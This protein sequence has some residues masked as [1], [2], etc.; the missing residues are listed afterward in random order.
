MSSKTVSPVHP[1]THH[2]SGMSY[3]IMGYAIMTVF[4]TLLK[5]VSQSGLYP[6][7]QMMATVGLFCAATIALVALFTGGLRGR[8]GT[9]KLAFHLWRGLLSLGAFFVGF[10]ALRHIPLVDFYGII[11]AIP[12]FV[13]LLSV[14]WL[15]EH[16]GW[17]RWTAIGCGFIGVLLMLRM[18][19]KQAPSAGE[20]WG[21]Y[22][23]LG[24]A[25]LNAL[26]SVMV[27]RYG[28]GESNLTFSFYTAV[29][30]IAVSG[31]LWLWSGG[32]AFAAFDLLLL[33]LAGV[34]VGFGSILLMTAFQR[35]P[36][37]AVAPFQYTQL[38]WGAVLGYWLFN[39]VPS[40]WS[41]TGAGIVIG[42][43]LL[44]LWREA[45]LARAIKRAAK[46]L[47]QAAM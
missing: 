30:N 20:V 17:P 31:A 28:R 44:V 3:A 4:D 38:V 41:L 23:A 2:L 7:P 45:A 14:F 8:L 24:C 18:G 11:F 6:Q 27:R 43:G 47:D 10:Y 1:A 40:F 37:P 9:K 15:K 39:E 21:Y 34:L 16:V 35:S 25:V 22:A 42:S 33:A 46:V 5:Q 36:P 19:V 13:T 29:C 26:T 12:I 32:A